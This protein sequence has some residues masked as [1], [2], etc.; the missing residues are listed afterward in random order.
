MAQPIYLASTESHSAKSTVALGLLHI[1]NSVME[2]TAV[3]RPIVRDEEE[4]DQ[5]LELLLPHTSSGVSYEKC[6]GVTY[7]EIHTNAD[8][9]L[10]KIIDRYRAVER[11][12]DL[13]LV[14]GSD[15]TGIA[16]PAE[17]DYN[18]DIAANI[19]A[20]VILV[21]SAFGKPTDEIAQAA[22]LA[23]DDMKTHHATVVGVVANRVRE[24]QLGDVGEALAR[25]DVPTW[26][27][28]EIPLLAAA[29][30]GEIK[31][32][33]GAELVY[34]D[35]ELMAREA[36]D[37]LLTGMSVEHVLERLGESQLVIT[38]SDRHGV[39]VSLLTAH[40]ADSFPSLAGIILNGG[41]DLPPS[42]DRL[43]RGF[44]QRL[45]ILT[46]DHDSF[47]AVSIASRTRGTLTPDTQRKADLA[48]ATFERHVTPES[49][50][51]RVDFT[52]PSIVT[53][54][55]FEARLLERARAAAKHIVLPEGDD[56]R[57]LRAASTLLARDVARLTILGDE[58]SIRA[59][60]AE[61]SLDI[62]EAEIISPNDPEMVDRFATEYAKLRA[63]KGMTLERAHELV[64]DVSFFGTMMVHLG[65]VDGMVSG[66]TH[67]TA[68]TIRPSFQIIKTKPGVGTVSSVFLML[69]EDRVLVYGDCAVIPVP[70][71]EQLADIAISSAETAKQFGV[72]PR[73][74]MLS[75]STGTSG[76]GADVEKVRAATELV[77][78]RAP[79]LSIEG[80]IQYDAA[81]DAAVA[82]AKLP[83]SKVAG[84]ATVFVFPDLNTGNN[85]Y[86]AV[87][88]SAGAVAVG[89]V[90]QG[91][92][93]PI[94]DLSRGALVHDIVNTVAITAI[95]AEAG[96]PSAKQ[97]P[98]HSDPS[99]S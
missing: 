26:A 85:T 62:S 63:H 98:N 76:A 3:F 22:R 14:V 66:A 52:P 42:V 13:V 80:P 41:F 65:L 44:G 88:R 61:L 87:Q 17:L 20:T 68:H 33:L 93:K 45:P 51:E 6:V 50:L 8:N 72:E 92:N 77:R 35:E 54:L 59:R 19:G 58:K 82:S 48:L 89:P 40:A 34:G 81:V 12:A 86:K 64:Q 7:K 74:A 57:I 4:R 25:L 69:L 56:D 10:A 1:F 55:M 32:A 43:V 67:T 11:E 30:V 23:L 28:P 31:E 96:T 36:E 60:A 83:G 15:Y 21:M 9:A 99:H 29:T 94:N 18:A 39:L 70:T 75:Y 95:Q 5:V 49:V 38:P 73:V 37:I 2:R 46:T 84:R 27:L 24:G 16:S 97:Q 78:E 79:Q 90:L 47:T 71:V 53:P 91:L